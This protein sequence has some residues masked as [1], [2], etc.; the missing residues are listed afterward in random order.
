MAF[1]M[2]IGIFILYKNNNF[3][4]INKLDMLIL[5]YLIYNLISFIFFIFSDLPIS[6]YFMEFSNSILPIILFYFFGR[7]NLDNSFY[8]ITLYALA[9]CFAIGF[10]FQ[11][12]VPSNYMAFM[13]NIDGIG[14][15][16]L[17]YKLN[18]RSYLGLT[19]TGSLSAIGVLLSFNLM[20]KRNFKA[21]K[22]IFL[23][24]FLALILTFRRAA[25]YTGLFA[26]I[27]MNYL[28]IFKFK[29]A[30]SKI[31]ILLVEFVFMCSALYWLISSNQEFLDDLYERFYSFSDAI[32]SR[33]DTWL[34]GLSN[35]Q[36]ILF[37]D[38]LGR[39]GHKAVEYSNLY[40][41]DGNYFRMIAELGVLGFL[42]FMLIIIISVYNGFSK[43]KNNYIEL[44][45]VIII[46][47]QAVGS[48]VF[49]F[50]LIAPV[51]WYSVGRC[52][53]YKENKEYF[54]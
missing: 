32:E 29:G 9:A 15:N 38:G 49:S 11:L 5:L 54:K 47:L 7:L 19:A 46:C 34:K 45:I 31:K 33:S 28:I 23:I 13:S 18:Y 50:Q 52:S 53:I 27:W 40:I 22:I 43:I 10:Y 4:L 42:L 25:L 6:V 24:C 8:N 30:K 2:C 36:N 39:Y 26:L 14:Q 17:S 1:I 12:T 44:C 41:P 51:F 3:K 21:G 35:T 16:P 48:N 20:Y 37:G